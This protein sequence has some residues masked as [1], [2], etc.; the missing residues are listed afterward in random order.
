MVMTT[1]LRNIKDTG[2]PLRGRV[3]TL[4]TTDIWE[5]AVSDLLMVST[6]AI[7]LPLHKLYRSSTGLLRWKKLGMYMQILFQT[8]WLVLWVR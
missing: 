3:W 2:Y 5:L 8:A 6:T 1:G 7:A 4:F